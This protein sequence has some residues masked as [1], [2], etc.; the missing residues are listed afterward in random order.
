MRRLGTLQKVEQQQVSQLSDLEHSAI[1]WH[2]CALRSWCEP[3]TAF[4]RPMT[5]V[6]TAAW[7]CLIR[8][9][10]NCWLS[11]FI[12][13]MLVAAAY[14]K[15]ITARSQKAQNGVERSCRVQFEHFQE[16]IHEHLGSLQGT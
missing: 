8:V 13:Y 11:K 9:D 4:H 5:T 6:S 14:R 3:P 15:Y 12:V 2:R 1:L 16:E 7:W 10:Q